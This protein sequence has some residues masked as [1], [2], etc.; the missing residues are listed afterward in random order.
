MAGRLR[1]WDGGALPAPVEAAVRAVPREAF[2]P[3]TPLEDAYR[4]S[5]VVTH[6]DASGVATSLLPGVQH[7]DESGIGR[8]DE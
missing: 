3:G 5:P 7:A 1:D 4:N 6:R 8:A 2:L